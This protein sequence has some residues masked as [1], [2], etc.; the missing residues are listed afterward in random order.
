MTDQ[1]S[2]YIPVT[3]FKELLDKLPYVTPGVDLLTFQA[4]NLIL[5]IGATTATERTPAGHVI[6]VKSI[7]GDP[8]VGDFYSSYSDFIEDVFKR[9]KGKI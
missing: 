7:D 9:Y 4:N 3:S 8:H 1:G 6:F 2:N 5:S